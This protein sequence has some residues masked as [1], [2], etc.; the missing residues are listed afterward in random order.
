MEI[1]VLKLEEGNIV[2]DNLSYKQLLKSV[3]I[4]APNQRSLGRIILNR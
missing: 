3:K 1:K 2:I 4:T